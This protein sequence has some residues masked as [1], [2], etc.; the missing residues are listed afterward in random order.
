MQLSKVFHCLMLTLRD[1]NPLCIKKHFAA[2]LK[3]E[4]VE[5]INKGMNEEC[6]IKCSRTFSLSLFI[7]LDAR[8][9]KIFFNCGTLSRSS[10]RRCHGSKFRM[11][12]H[13]HRRGVLRGVKNKG[14]RKF[15]FLEELYIC[16]LFR[17]LLFILL[18]FRSF[19]LWEC[20][21]IYFPQCE[22][23]ECVY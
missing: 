17:F 11:P 21:R 1:E 5:K 4:K 15:F 14:R 7:S 10:S 20:V 16:S 3:K 19:P 8:K 2:L 6:F 12:L 13:C 9:K 22:L 23:C 18:L